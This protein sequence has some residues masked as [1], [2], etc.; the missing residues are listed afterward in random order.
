MWQSRCACRAVSRCT[1]RVSPS[2]AWSFSRHATG[3]FRGLMGAAP[4]LA[5]ANTCFPR[6]TCDCRIRAGPLF[7]DVTVTLVPSMKRSQ[8]YLFTPSGITPLDSTILQHQAEPNNNAKNTI[9]T[10]RRGSIPS[11]QQLGRW[12]RISQNKQP[13]FPKLGISRPLRAAGCPIAPA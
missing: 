2:V 5:A 8:K 7:L 11:H 12:L 4:A 13:C 3:P 6:I 9:A 1:L 10:T